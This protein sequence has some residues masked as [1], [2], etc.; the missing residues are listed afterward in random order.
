VRASHTYHCVVWKI[1]HVIPR[2]SQNTQQRK[3]VVVVS[4]RKSRREPRKTV[5]EPAIRITVSLDSKGE[6]IEDE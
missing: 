1:V 5:R 4:V 3:R 2:S 6:I